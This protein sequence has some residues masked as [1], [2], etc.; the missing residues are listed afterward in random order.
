MTADDRILVLM[1]TAKDGER[2]RQALTAA[3]LDCIVCGDLAELCGE[4]VRGAGAALLTEEVVA[5]D[6]AGRLQKALRARRTGRICPWS[7]WH[8]SVPATGT[9]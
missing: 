2:T 1:P 9:I 8:A 7:F 3:G 4:I 5:H 6:P